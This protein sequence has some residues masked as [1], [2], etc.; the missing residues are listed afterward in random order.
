MS[1]KTHKAIMMPRR[2]PGTDHPDKKKDRIA[3]KEEMDSMGNDFYSHKQ[4]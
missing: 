1:N 2:K 3:E 4:L